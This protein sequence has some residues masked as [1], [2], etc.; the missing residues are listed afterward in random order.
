LRMGK[1]MASE[2]H[3]LCRPMNS[4]SCLGNRVWGCLHLPLYF[5]VCCNTSFLLETT[6]SHIA[7][8]LKKSSASLLVS[9]SLPHNSFWH[10]NLKNFVQNYEEEIEQAYQ[11]TV[12]T[13]LQHSLWPAS[14]CIVTDDP[15]V[16]SRYKHKY[17]SCC[18]DIFQMSLDHLE[19]NIL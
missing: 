9:A 17:L 8:R 1:N 18:T 5:H 19:K 15:P 2:I 10:N 12:I 16:V 3:T 13:S 11:Y 6:W 14:P 4:D 7:T